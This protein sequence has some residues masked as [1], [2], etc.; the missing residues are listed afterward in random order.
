M[1]L[2][3]DV[4]TGV[5]TLRKSPGY[6]LTAILTLGLGIGATTATF[7]FCDA[8]L[9]KPLPLPRVDSLAMIAE[10]DPESPASVR[11]L[12]PADFD[13]IRS[14]SSAFAGL[15]SWDDN[16]ANLVE[17]ASPPERID[18]ASVSANFFEVLGVAPERGRAFLPGEDQRGGELVVI[19]GD[20]L[21]HRR[22]GG[23][24]AIA[25]RL[26]HLNDKTYRVV[27]VMP[28]G[29]QFPK[30]AE[31]WTPLVLDPSAA[32]SR[33]SPEFVAV[34]RLK[35]GLAESDAAREIAAIGARLARQHPATNQDRAFRV[36]GVQQ[37][38]MGDVRRQ[39]IVLLFG[40][41]LFVLLIACA[42]VANLQFARALSRMREVAVRA[43]LGAGRGRLMAQ[44]LT[45]SVLLALAGGALGLLVASWGLDAWRASLP[46]DSGKSV[47]RLS[48][49]ALDRRALLFALL[50]AV[51]SGILSGLAPAWQWARPNLYDALKE[52]GGSAV[53]N[54]ARHRLRT[55]L[56]A[57]EIA[58]T[59]VLLVGAGLMIRGFRAL[60]RSGADLDPGSLLT[61]RLAVTDAKY[62]EDYQLADFYRRVLER[63][64][65]V[66][67]VRAA[68]GAT[69]TPY[70]D[71]VTSRPFAIEGRPPTPGHTPA[72]ALQAVSANY[73]ETM[74]V[75]LIA[76]RVIEDR[77]T[78]DAPRVAVVSRRVARQWFPGGESPLGRR[79]RIGD[80]ARERPWATIVGVVGDETF[81]VFDRAPH[82][83]LYVPNA[84][85]PRERMDIGV[86]VSGDP[87][88]LVSPIA[89]AIHSVDPEQPV[90][91]V[92]TVD[93]Q[94]R[95]QALGLTYV[96]A[97][98]GIFGGIGLVLSSIGVYAVM[99]YT[100]SEQTHEIGIRMALGAP[101]RT[102]LRTVFRRG[103]ATTAVGLAAGLVTA[104][105]LTRLMASMIWGVGAGDLVTFAAV[106]VALAAAA[107]LAIYL[108]AHHA[109]R[110]DPMAALRHE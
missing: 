66:P 32:V 28:P 98:L 69:S 40:A 25:G 107:S 35:P 63:V 1:N 42:N 51:A 92:R 93:A 60:T 39:Y 26:V 75:P 65:A 9:W 84:Q 102:V 64:A 4:K 19:L 57:G 108:P 109:I 68:A 41:V 76:G 104:L 74:R 50:A 14:Q 73:F 89:A 44:L 106:P 97:L 110:I 61:L 10:R 90:T 87:A 82:A 83:T 16:S 37:F 29:F 45:E 17:P 7:S 20:E 49:I 91:D 86:R 78:A 27:G 21:W 70:S 31:L 12:T 95:D 22:F 85:A 23:D 101:R 81:S 36:L 96:A 48:D 34:G 88:R 56:V 71:H 54:R 38:L 2:W 47:L 100:V 46:A 79:I 13:D 103:M 59:V 30:R 72:A 94:I 18:S 43:A 99:A 24:P 11:N 77:D 8:L 67:G 3:R 52:R 53:G 15:A 58:L 55:G 6:A 5:R 105:A 33:T 62:A 80:P